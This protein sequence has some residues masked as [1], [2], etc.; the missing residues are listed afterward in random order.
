MADMT[1]GKIK[2]HVL[3]VKFSMLYARI[4][5]PLLCMY[6]VVKLAKYLWW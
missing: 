2:M 4:G 3:F 6:G 5:L 1:T